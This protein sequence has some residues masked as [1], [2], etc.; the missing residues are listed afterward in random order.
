MMTFGHRAATRMLAG[1]LLAV[2]A[3]CSASDGSQAPGDGEQTGVEGPAPTVAA[4]A[5][6]AA[7]FVSAAIEGGDASA[8]LATAATGDGGQDAFD[9]ALLSARLD[10][11]RA[12][13]GSVAAVRPSTSAYP[14]AGS[15]LAPACG[16]SSGLYCQVD[17]VGDGDQLLASV[18]V[19]WFGDG[20]TD[21]S[22]L[23]RDSAGEATGIGEARCSAGLRLLHG[24]HT[25]DRFD[26]AV[27]VDDAGR[28]EYN[29]WE[30]GTD[31]GIRLAGCQDGPERW[32]ATNEGYVYLVDGSSS[33]VTSHIRVY[34]PDGE[35]ALEGPFT[36]VE[37]PAPTAP[38]SCQQ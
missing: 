15:G 4:G 31:S 25:P 7:E 35:L 20:V 36:A 10:E 32:T 17:L 11:L 37:L 12:F 13:E 26:I 19:Y 21:F 5:L 29:G 22:I 38:A 18:V 34:D 27:C 28:I 8:R 1:L 6:A 3:G 24:G 16:Q 9:A 33:P 23:I 2:G 30:R 14:D